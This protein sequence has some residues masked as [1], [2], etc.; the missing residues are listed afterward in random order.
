MKASITIP[1]QQLQDLLFELSTGRSSKFLFAVCDDPQQTLSA[2]RYIDQ[3]LAELGKTVVYLSSETLKD[4]LL[5]ILSEESKAGI[6][7]V[8]GIW[9]MDDL[10]ADDAGRLFVQLNFHRDWLAK[11]KLPIVLWISSDLLNHLIN[12]A[13]DF[14]S[15]RTSVYYL[16]KRSTADLL[17]KL[18]PRTG[19]SAP[20]WAPEPSLSDAFDR[21]LSSERELPERSEERRVGKE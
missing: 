6:A 10:D 1:D 5:G 18:F 14:W 9:G 7:D 3:Q 17:A 12:V 2:R 4:N 13:P 8:I 20:Q 19:G 11:L 15:R 16:T 21:I